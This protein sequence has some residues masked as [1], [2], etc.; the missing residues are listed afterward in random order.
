MTYEGR[1]KISYRVKR[2]GGLDDLPGGGQIVVQGDYA[3]VGHMDPPYGTSII[4]VSDPANPKIAA[5]IMLEGDAS[6]S[7]KVR[8]VGD[9]MYVNVEQS[10][11]HFKRKSAGIAAAEAALAAETGRPAIPAPFSPAIILSFCVDSR[12]VFL[13][14]ARN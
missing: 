7:H 5:Q 11:R 3:Y 10:D 4:D 1:E 14:C 9:L 2:L 13:E 8:V 12:T 6:H